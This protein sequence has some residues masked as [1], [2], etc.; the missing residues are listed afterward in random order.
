M[1]EWKITTITETCVPKMR[2]A[3][4]RMLFELEDE[5]FAIECAKDF[6]DATGLPFLCPDSDEFEAFHKLQKL[7]APNPVM[8][9]KYRAYEGGV[10][11]AFDLGIEDMGITYDENEC[12][13]NPFIPVRH[14][15]VT[16]ATIWGM[17]QNV[18]KNI[19]NETNDYGID[20]LVEVCLNCDNYNEVRDAIINLLWRL[21]DEREFY[22]IATEQDI[23]AYFF[24]FIYPNLHKNG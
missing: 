7:L 12:E 9:K 19:I 21:Y 23:I 8:P 16:D 1:F 24:I 10:G 4:N 5:E 20:L 14:M 13:F 15:E 2:A 22:G 6:L 11:F 3:V 17:H 18:F